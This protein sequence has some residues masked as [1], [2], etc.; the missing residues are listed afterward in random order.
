MIGAALSFGAVILLSASPAQPMT[1]KQVIVALGDSTTAGTPFFASSVEAPPEGAGDPKAPFTY[2]MMQKRPQWTVLN[3]GVNGERTDE[4]HAR[5]KRDVL[6]AHPSVMILLGGVNDVYQGYPLDHIKSELTAMITEARS[7]GIVPVPATVLPFS[8]ASA[9]QS[10][11]IRAV[12]DWLRQFAKE[13]HLTLCDLHS[14]VADPSN[15]DR[16]KG[17]PEG[18]HPDRAGYRAMGEALVSCVEQAR[19]AR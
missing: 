5:M 19:S 17:S 11:A 10:A 7:H 9:D 3:R 16:L 4:I 2:W 6:D 15:P 13:Q 1:Q 18:L 14:V 12:N 8:L